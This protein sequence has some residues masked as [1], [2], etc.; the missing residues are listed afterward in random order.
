MS[1]WLKGW[2]ITPIL[3]RPKHP[4][5]NAKVERAQGTTSRWAEI[6]KATN[7]QD[8]QQRL[9][10]IICEQRDKYLVKR[11]H[12]TTRTQVFPDLYENR[13]IFE[14]NKFD[15]QATYE[16]L[17]SKTLQRK[18]SST[19]IVALYG[20][21]LQVHAKFKGQY[22]FLKFDANNIAWKVFNSQKEELK[23]IP[24]QRFKK[25]N[26]ILLTVCQ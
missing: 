1:L 10:A 15:I 12:Y 23:T 3:N 11:F 18:V 6:H 24:D 19:G 26:I 25:E 20:K 21:H 16:L 13:R 17:A 22:V 4:Q 14:E 2:G 5:D 9:D 7:V 8:L